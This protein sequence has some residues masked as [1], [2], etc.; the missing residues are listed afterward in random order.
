LWFIW[1]RCR[2]PVYDPFFARHVPTVDAATRAGVPARRRAEFFP[3]ESR[4]AL[5]MPS[6]DDFDEQ[7][8]ARSAGV[9]QT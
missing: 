2:V 7:F 9:V 4:P 8:R 6:A 5:S 3:L 1:W